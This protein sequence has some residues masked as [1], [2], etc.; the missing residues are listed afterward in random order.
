VG[1]LSIHGRALCS[2]RR[3]VLNGKSGLFPCSSHVFF[4]IGSSAGFVFSVGFLWCEFAWL[5]L[6][7]S[8]RL[9]FCEPQATP[10]SSGR[11]NHFGFD[12]QLNRFCFKFPLGASSLDRLLCSPLDCS[13][14]SPRWL[15]QLRSG[16]SHFLLISICCVAGLL[17]S[18]ESVPIFFPAHA[19]WI[20]RSQTKAS[21]VFPAAS[22]CATKD[23][24]HA[25][26]F[27]RS[28]F[29]VGSSASWSR[30]FAFLLAL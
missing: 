9:P 27:S 3:C 23:L 4:I 14:M 24:A 25:P 20:P 7:L 8:A 13:A 16:Q 12:G 26:R 5:A 18:S 30:S 29:L 19:R 15:N 6:V 21:P 1:S 22:I 11:L 17:S 10:V 28:E 2:A